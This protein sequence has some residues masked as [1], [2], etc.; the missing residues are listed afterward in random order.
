[1]I[2]TLRTLGC[3][4][5]IVSAAMPARFFDDIPG[6][7]ILGN[8]NAGVISLYPSGTELLDPQ[9]DPAPWDLTIPISGL[10]QAL[11][12]SGNEN[13]NGPLGFNSLPVQLHSTGHILNL[14]FVNNTGQVWSGLWLNLEL[15]YGTPSGEDDG[16]SFSRGVADTSSPDCVLPS[17]GSCVFDEY[18]LMITPTSSNFASMAFG[19]GGLTGDYIQFSNGS[20]QPGQTALV[21][22]AITNQTSNGLP[23]NP[24]FLRATPSTTV[25]P[26]PSSA[27]LFAGGLIGVIA[28]ARR[29]RRSAKS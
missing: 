20:I 15:D 9:S 16:I 28:A 12:F 1:M 27:L 21:S 26:E 19:F 3:F 18:A 6:D 24:F 29:A 22:F 13:V 2:S 7:G 10:D 4:F 25:V 14:S 8:E 11:Q 5:L 23:N 17:L